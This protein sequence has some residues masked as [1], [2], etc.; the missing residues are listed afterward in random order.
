MYITVWSNTTTCTCTCRLISG[1]GMLSHMTVPLQTP[2]HPRRQY[3]LLVSSF[4]HEGHLH[5]HLHWRRR[6]DQGE[7]D[8]TPGPPACPSSSV[9][10]PP[11]HELPETKT[12]TPHG[13]GLHSRTYQGGGWAGTPCDLFIEGSVYTVVTDRKHCVTDYFLCYVT[14]CINSVCT[15]LLFSSSLYPI[16]ST[17][18]Q[19]QESARGGSNA[20]RRTRTGSRDHSRWRVRLLAREYP[21]VD[22]HWTSVALHSH[23]QT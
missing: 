8:R 6:G 15:Y 13:Q 11:Q 21:R 9:A 19:R 1:S 17:S 16:K 4:E 14:V 2:S 10:S 3:P 23:K 7:C 12:H 20:R 22:G 5:H 18:Y